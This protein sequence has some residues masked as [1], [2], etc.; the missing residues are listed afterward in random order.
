LR[1]RAGSRCGGRGQETIADLEAELAD[2]D[3]ARRVE[4]TAEVEA[5]KAKFRRIPF[6]DP[7]DIRYRRFETIPS[8]SRQAV[9]FCLMDVSARCPST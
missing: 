2:C 3:E 6:I 8:R 5:L 7:I 4:V 9:M 1:W